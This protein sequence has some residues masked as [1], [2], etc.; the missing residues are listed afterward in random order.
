MSESAQLNA[1]SLRRFYARADR[2]MLV[3]LWVCLLFSAALGLV[4]GTW[5]QAL[6]VGGGTVLV[7]HLLHQ[8]IGGQRLFRCAMA[9]ALMVMSA[10]HINQAA[11]LVEMHFAIFV[12]LALLVYYR[13]WLPVVVAALV[14][15]VH[16]LTFYYLQSS[17]SGVFVIRDGGWGVIFLHAG[18][19]LVETAVLVYLARQSYTDALEGEALGEATM[20]MVGDGGRTD[21]TYRVPMQTE[22]II[23][24]NGFVDNLDA[25]IGII[26]NEVHALSELGDQLS[27]RAAQLDEGSRRQAEE[28]RYMVQAMAEL[29]TATHQVARSA[30]DAAKA[31]GKAN[32]QVEQGNTAMQHIS[33]A[34]GNLN[35]DIDLTSEA[36]AGAADIANEIYQV[37]DAIKAVAEQT[38]LLALNAAI[39]AARAGEQGRG[40]A[41]VADEVRNLSQRTAQSTA[42]IQNFIERLQKASESARDSMLRSQG[43]VRQCLEAAEAGAQTLGEV[44]AEIAHISQLNTQI[45]TATHQQSTVGEDVARHLQ[46]VGGI[47]SGNA[48]Q[49]AD[50]QQLALDMATLRSRLAEQ[51]RH[52]HTR[53][54]QENA[55]YPA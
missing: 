15:A 17:G 24:F 25:S 13:D 2:A 31:A 8:L 7:I 20:R 51:V 12:L 41:V 50:L 42:E 47:A 37:V 52:F 38:N 27:Q 54:H 14:I 35:Q 36:V 46:E 40:F 53:G 5:M 10:L 43:S 6:L 16:H 3:V 29:S 44:V 49:S 22:M 23:S 39:E 48:E 30:D 32:L 1:L 21:L 4:Y 26:N 33:Q 11:G 9:T 19:V 28:S 55:D 45:A 18:Y 34:I